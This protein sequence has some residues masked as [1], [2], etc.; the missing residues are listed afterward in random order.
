M[1][2]GQGCLAE[3]F[4]LAGIAFAIFI[5]LPSCIVNGVTPKLGLGGSMSGAFA[6]GTLSSGALAAGANDRGEFVW[7][8][9]PGGLSW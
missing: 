7:P 9:R 8:L 2:Q 6:A 5:Y 4:F 3:Q 1:V